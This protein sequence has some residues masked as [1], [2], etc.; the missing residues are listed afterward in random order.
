MKKITLVLIALVSCLS[1]ACPFVYAAGDRSLTES[2]NKNAEYVSDYRNIPGVTKADIQAIEQLQQDKKKFTYGTMMSGEAFLNRDGSRSGFSIVL[3]AML[4]DMF[5]IP[6]EHQFYDWESLIAAL[7]SGQ[8]DFSGELRV[9]E[10]RKQRYYMT[11]G[12]YERT[13]KIFTNRYA[14]DVN[15]LA[16][17][18]PV[19]MGFLEGSAYRDEIARV[20]RTDFETVYVSE[21]TTAAEM[22]RNQ[23]IDAFIDA[24]PAVFNFEKYDFIRTEDFFPLLYFPIS[25]STANPEYM[26]I[27]RVVQLYLESGGDYYLSGLYQEGHEEFLSHK[28]DMSLTDEE[29]GYI[30]T[31]K[32]K[33]DAVRITAEPNNYPISFYNTKEKEFQGI[34]LDALDEIARLLGIHFVTVNTAQDTWTQILDMIQNH[35]AAL[36]AGTM[37]AEERSQAL[38]WADTPLAEDQCA[39]LTLANHADITLNQIRYAKVGLIQGSA[40]ADTYAKWFPDSANKVY[41]PS[42]KEA[43][44]ALKEGQVDFIIASQNLLLSQTNYYEDPA[45]KA[46]IVFNHNVTSTLAFN[47]QEALL[48][49]IVSKAQLLIPIEEINNRW[50]YKAFDYDS[51]R[52]KDSMPYLGVFFL[53]LLVAIIVILWAYLTNRHLSKNL[54]HLVK[55]RTRELELQTTTLEAVFSAIPDMIFCR[56]LAGRFTKCNESYEQFV[57]QK[58]EDIIG[59]YYEDLSE[60]DQHHLVEADEEVIRNQTPIT[61][62]QEM[63]SPRYRISRLFEV[64]RTPLIKNGK[65]MGIL[66]IARDITERRLKD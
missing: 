40:Y 31:L 59:K 15:V 53:I 4:Q 55:L 65:I 47:Q 58:Q 62:E 22:L 23:E 32:I 51:K 27:I 42:A 14:P 38:L 24:A 63:Y 21:Y 45:F 18:R 20:A 36:M 7:N 28:L 57:G 10:D 26:P 60:Q 19:R 17:I 16:E 30:E 64:I 13:I 11:E 1:F 39:L 3:C 46:S 56:D 41:Y 48:R 43:F 50:S 66:G 8:V 34:A 5:D 29:R 25:I 44:Q 37:N 2:L 12:I 52:L 61:S 33:N 49:S 6:F 9:T 54:E 35:Q